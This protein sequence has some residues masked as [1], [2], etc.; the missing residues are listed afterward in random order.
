MNI[1]EIVKWKAK[2]NVSDSQ[3]IEMVDAMVP[4]LKNI[5][6]FIDQVLYKDKDEYWIDVYYWD[7]VQNAHLSNERMADKASLKKLLELIQLETI[8]I[9]VLEPLQRAE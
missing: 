8:T 5:E 4:D 1:L 3:M 6:G 7:S 9:D 2:P